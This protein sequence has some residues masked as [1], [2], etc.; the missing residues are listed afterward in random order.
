[1]RFLFL[2]K[3]SRER[4]W[5][6]ENSEDRP[7]FDADI[8]AR[9]NITGSFFKAEFRKAMNADKGFKRWL[10]HRPLIHIFVCVSGFQPDADYIWV[11]WKMSRVSPIS[12]LVIFISKL[13]LGMPTMCYFTK[14]NPSVCPQRLSSQSTHGTFI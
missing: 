9:L 12:E 7:L 1:M 11:P 8:E 10:N 13:L 3:K 4:L 14:M 5:K 2:E 6:V